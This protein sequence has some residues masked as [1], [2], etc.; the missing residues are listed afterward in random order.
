MKSHLNIL[1]LLLL[2]GLLLNCHVL[3]AYEPDFNKQWHLH[4]TGQAVNGISG[5]AGIDINWISAMQYYKPKDRI[6]IAVL[7]TG[8]SVRH[9]EFFDP[10]NGRSIFWV[11][12]VEDEGKMGIDDDNNGYIDDIIGWSYSADLGLDSF[13]DRFGHGTNVTG[14]IAALDNGKYGNA[15][16]H[17]C[18]IMVVKIQDDG[19][20]PNFDRVNASANYARLNGAEIFNMSLGRDAYFQEEEDLYKQLSDQNILVIAAAGNGE[21]DGVGDN[22]DYMP[23]YP[24]CYSA[25]TIISVAAINQSG[26]LASFSNYGYMSVDIA[27]PGDN[28]YAIESGEKLLKPGYAYTWGYIKDHNNFASEW[29]VGYLNGDSAGNPWRYW[30]KNN[31]LVLGDSPADWWSSTYD[32]NTH[33]YALS[34]QID[35]SDFS[36]VEVG[37]WL[38]VDLSEGD[39][40]HIEIISNG[41]AEIVKTYPPNYSSTDK[42]DF[43]LNGYA[44]RMIQVRVRL[45]SNSDFYVNR[46]GV[47]IYGLYVRG[48]KIRHPTAFGSG[49]SF[50]AP[51]VT[52]VAGLV[53]SH[54]PQFDRKASEGSHFEERQ[55]APDI[56]WLCRHRWHG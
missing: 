9:D 20:Q 4:N 10:Q 48:Y 46:D 22:N 23:Q 14:L 39:Y 55:T 16:C 28:I 32:D 19:P 52:G 38:D 11:N 54:R 45:Y 31:Y 18:D 12:H 13:V 50:A 42:P 2:F 25:D 53:W 51:I 1:W 47:D 26:Q 15:L 21:P 35:L 5:T 43:T 36:S 3:D 37:M 29:T 7:D 17:E 41:Q 33:S 24:A 44:G 6:T 34:K 40:A 30:D 49:T 8:A 56:V 27:A